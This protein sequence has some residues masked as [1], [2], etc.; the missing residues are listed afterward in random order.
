MLQFAAWGWTMAGLGAP[1]ARACPDCDIGQVARA[2]FW[3]DDFAIHL[4]AALAPFAVVVAAS[5]L[6]ERMDRGTKHARP[7]EVSDER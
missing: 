1:V 2:Q 7:D 6:A 3:S 5:F 4:G